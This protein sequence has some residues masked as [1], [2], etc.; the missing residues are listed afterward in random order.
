MQFVGLLEVLG[1][2]ECSVFHMYHFL[3]SLDCLLSIRATNTVYR[4]TIFSGEDDV[5]LF[6]SA[7]YT[8]KLFDQAAEKHVFLFR[9]EWEPR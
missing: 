7:C 8:P 6:G 2:N 1:L 3:G 9:N 4:Q 5:V